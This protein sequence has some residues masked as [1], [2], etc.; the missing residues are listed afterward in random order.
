[1]DSNL[2]QSVT[3]SPIRLT[4]ERW[5]HIVDTHCELAGLR[6]EI[7]ETI[8]RPERVLAGGGGERLAVRELEPGKWLVVVYREDLGDGFVITAFLT[9]RHR[10]LERRQQLWPSQQ[11]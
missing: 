7:L 3:G 1:M 8:V 11:N 2:E 5:A 9:R 6:D 4:A 10:S